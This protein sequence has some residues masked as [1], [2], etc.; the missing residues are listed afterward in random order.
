LA[1]R[2]AAAIQSL[3]GELAA[4]DFADHA[5]Q[6]YSPISTTYRGV[7]VYETTL[8]TQGHIVL[9]E[10][11]ILENLDLAGLGHNSAEALHWLIEAKK[12][13]FADRNAYSRDPAFG[14]TP[15]DTLLSK[16]FAAQRFASIDANRA[17]D[18]VAPG[19]LDGDTT[20]LC[21]ADGDG[22][23]VSFIHS[24]SAGFGSHVVA[25]DTGIM[26]NN[27]AGRGFSL[28]AEHPNVIEGGK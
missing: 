23:M 12:R 5:S 28:E 16:E 21:T 11:N 19:E 24:N 14:P 10:L 26:L 6:L 7:T 13:A 18:E 17:S 8:P 22:N 2:I 27:R 4:D 15:L 1:E 9:E 3:G 25:G 20:Y